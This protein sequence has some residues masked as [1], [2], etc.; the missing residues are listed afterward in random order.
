MKIQGVSGKSGVFY[1]LILTQKTLSYRFQTSATCFICYYRGFASLFHKN[2]MKDERATYNYNH[3]GQ[4]YL[5]RIFKRPFWSRNGHSEAVFVTIGFKVI[6]F[7]PL[8]L[9]DHQDFKFCEYL[10]QGK[11]YVSFCYCGWF[12]Q[13][14]IFD[15]W[16]ILYIG[17]RRN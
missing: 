5:R 2:Q 14:L 17:R 8:V 1:F 6:L 7:T 13:F 16:A 3:M 10:Y 4:F 15:N 12:F 9:I 11:F